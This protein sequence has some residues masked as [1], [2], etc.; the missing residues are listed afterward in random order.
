MPTMTMPPK[1]SEPTW[2][3]LRVLWLRAT[4]HTNRA[5]GNEENLSEDTVKMHLRRIYARLGVNT[6]AEAVAACYQ[7][8][9][10]PFEVAGLHRLVEFLGVECEDP[11]TALINRCASVE[12]DLA[13]LRTHD[14]Y[15]QFCREVA[16]AQI[17]S[18]WTAAA[19]VG[20]CTRA[21]KRAQDKVTNS[22]VTDRRD[23]PTAVDR[24]LAHIAGYIHESGAGA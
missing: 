1:G 23:Y 22:P 21:A 9:L 10:R 8:S 11:V 5:V 19:A 18:V 15:D 13:D 12:M 24:Q 14:F 7:R 16:V 6:A 17:P 3:E 2:I 4:G 20:A